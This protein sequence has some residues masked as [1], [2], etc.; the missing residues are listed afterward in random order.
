MKRL[1]YLTMNLLVKEK[2]PEPLL[3]KITIRILSDT[4][5][6]PDMTDTGMSEY[7]GKVLR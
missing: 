7:L 3:V 2:V 6:C 4:T 1:D 5:F